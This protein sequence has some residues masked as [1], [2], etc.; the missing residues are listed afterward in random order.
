MILK[1]NMILL[2][3]I[4][5]KIKKEYFTFEALIVPK[6][7]WLIVVL[8]CFKNSCCIIHFKNSQKIVKNCQN[9]WKNNHGTSKLLILYIN[10]SFLHWKKPLISE[11]IN[12]M[13]FPFSLQWTLIA[14]IFFIVMKSSL[15]YMYN[16]VMFYKLIN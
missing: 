8:F 9:E 2:N 3:N 6:K 15:A 10:S 13:N 5:E 14:R 7:V 12:T 11:T 1:Y 16:S 4:N